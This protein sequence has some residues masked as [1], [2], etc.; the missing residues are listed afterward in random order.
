MDLGQD[1][2]KGH[3]QISDLPLEIVDLREDT[4]LLRKPFALLSES[5]LEFFKGSLTRYGHSEAG[6]V[7]KEEDE[8]AHASRMAGERDETISEPGTPKQHTPTFPLSQTPAECSNVSPKSELLSVSNGDGLALPIDTSLQS[9]VSEPN[10]TL[11]L[12]HI[13]ST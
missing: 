11:A 4:A 10:W 7:G 5:T 3:V 8:V 1:A 9:E 6:H 2:A 13:T 12:R